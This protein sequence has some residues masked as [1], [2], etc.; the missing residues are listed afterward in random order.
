M[1]TI[2]RFCNAC[3]A[4]SDC[5]RESLATGPKGQWGIQG[6][7]TQEQR[8]VSLGVPAHRAYRRPGRTV[9]GDPDKESAR[10][11][12]YQDGLNDVELA[13]EEESSPSTIRDWRI[14]R[15]LPPNHKA[16]AR[17]ASA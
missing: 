4:R 10:M 8:R 6:G 14:R 13:A 5:L 9:R 1:D 17:K 7:M 11:A 15:G 2:A 3:P 12:W 16:N